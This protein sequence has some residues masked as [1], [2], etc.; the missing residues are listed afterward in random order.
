MIELVDVAERAFRLKATAWITTREVDPSTS[1]KDHIEVYAGLVQP[2]EMALSVQDYVL[3]LFVD[4]L[5]VQDTIEDGE[6]SIGVTD[7][8]LRSA[9]T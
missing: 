3:P 2:E 4:A 5:T 8:E 7:T 1:R 6:V 9:E